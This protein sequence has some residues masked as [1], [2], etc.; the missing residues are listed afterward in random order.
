MASERT[1]VC[2][3]GMV[4]SFGTTPADLFARRAAGSPRLTPTRVRR[5]GG[6]FELPVHAADLSRLLE[7]IPKRSIR[8]I[9]RLSGLS[10]LAAH[11]ALQDAGLP[12]VGERTG[13]VLA[14]GYGASHSTGEFLDSII[15]GAD[16]GASPTAFAGS[17]HCSAASQVSIGLG[18]RGPTLTVTQF[19]LSCGEALRV[20]CR[21]LASGRV[22]TVLAGAADEYS[23][24]VGSCWQRLTA[25]LF[26]ATAE[27]APAPGEG[28][29]FLV[30]Q[31]APADG[32]AAAGIG[33]VATGARWAPAATWQPGIVVLGDDGLPC[34]QSQYEQ[35]VPAGLTTA[36]L[37]P[38]Y[39]VFPASQMLDVAAVLAAWRAGDTKSLPGLGRPAA[40]AP[41]DGPNPTSA[42]CLKFDLDGRYSLIEPTFC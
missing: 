1:Q 27:A 40:A 34:Q 18:I 5:A 26:P 32:P 38:F 21:W 31:R 15:D 33:S 14:T 23:D 10:L 29:A 22:D 11:L 37:T 24:T 12:L 28:A 42:A 9:D 25:G 8:R 39:G 4:G 35:A 3:I 36:C 20:A 17:V 2:G 13:L 6:T 19:E 41:G 16:L 7:F 30:L